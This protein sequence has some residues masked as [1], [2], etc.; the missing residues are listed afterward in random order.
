MTWNFDIV[1]PLL[2]QIGPME[3]PTTYNGHH[4]VALL[5]NNLQEHLGNMPLI[6]RCNKLLQIYLSDIRT[7]TSETTGLLYRTCLLY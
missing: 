4:F 3:L 2:V 7:D 6:Y 5:R 1:Q